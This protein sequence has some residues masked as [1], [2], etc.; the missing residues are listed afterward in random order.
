MN[1]SYVQINLADIIEAYGEND[2]KSILSS[3]SCKLNPDVEDFIRNKAISFSK[4]GLARTHL[5][6]WECEDGSEKELVGYYS[7]APK[8]LT[9]TK[10]HISNSSYKSICQFGFHDSHTDH[11]SIPAILIGQLGK[12]YNSGNDVLISGDEL[13]SLALEK[14]KDVQFESGGRYTYVECE[15]KP[16]LIDYYTRNG[17]IRFGDRKLDKDETNIHGEYLIQ[18]LKKL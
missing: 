10:G 4:H 18:F 12:N 14:V 3:F 9:V 6:Y 17:F 5:V 2:T 15:D 16:K 7:L 1:S 8:I 13:L 11:C